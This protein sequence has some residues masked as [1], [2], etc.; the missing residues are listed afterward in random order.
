MN[1]M[2][3]FSTGTD[4]SISPAILV[5]VVAAVQFIVPFLNSATFVALPEIG[6][7]LNASAFQLSLIQ[8]ALNLG[9]AS[10]VVPAGRFADIHGRKKVFMSGTAIACVA[11]L[12]LALAGTAEIFIALRVVLGIGC[13]LIVTTS[14]AIITTVFPAGKRGRIMGVVLGAVYLGMSLGPSISGF[15]ID[16]LGWQWIFFLVSGIE[17]LLLIVMFFKFKGEW[18]SARGEPFDWGGV[19][20]FILAMFLIIYG[21]TEFQRSDV[22]K[23]LALPGL[24]GMCFF[25]WLQWRSPY[26]ILDVHLLVDNPVFSFSSMATFINYASYYSFMFFFSLY[27]QFVKGLPPKFAG[28][29]FVVQPLMQAILSP[30]A[31]RLA[32]SYP[33]ARIATAGMAVCTVGVFMAATIDAGTSLI[34]ILVIASLVGLSLGLFSSPN[35]TAI[36]DSVDK[37]HV[38]NAS[39]MVSTMR[40]IGMLFSST[41]IAVFFSH[42]MGDQPVT[43]ANLDSFTYVMHIALYFFCV[44]SLVGTGFSMVT[45]RRAKR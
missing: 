28:L 10:F 34:L 4:E 18:T 23:W 43:N 29:L 40:S 14:I 37:R 41:I 25:V 45:G 2:T 3:D 26:P 30:I 42:F 24:V 1:T 33:P 31:G 44:L 36:M 16:Y 8:A 27:L 9:I 11:S 32:D 20:M 19:A 13:A 17:L 12:A 35:M 39:S 22:G 15:I 38:G 5:I 7:D 21:A 6:R